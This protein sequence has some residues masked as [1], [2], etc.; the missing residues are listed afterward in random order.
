MTVLALVFGPSRTR[1]GYHAGADHFNFDIEQCWRKVALTVVSA[2][3][4]AEMVNLATV[5][6]SL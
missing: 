6:V 1:T 3:I 4:Y 5:T 2:S